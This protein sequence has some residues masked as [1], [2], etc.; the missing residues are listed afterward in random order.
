L[1]CF[2]SFF[3]MTWIFILSRLLELLLFIYYSITFGIYL[4][5]H[6]PFASA[7]RILPSRMFQVL[8]FLILQWLD[9]IFK[10]DYYN[11]Y[12]YYL[13]KYFLFHLFFQLPVASACFKLCNLFFTS[14]FFTTFFI[15][16]FFLPF[17]LPFIFIF[18]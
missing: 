7:H 18:L 17:S 8:C 10:R 6:P 9:F 12:Y 14:R 2:A 11:Y 1:R 15:L 4:L 5:S 13:F 16:Y 3:C